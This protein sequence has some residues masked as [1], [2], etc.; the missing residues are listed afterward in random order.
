MHDNAAGFALPAKDLDA[1]HAY[2]NTSLVDL[3]FNS[4][5]FEVDFE[6]HALDKDLPDII[7]D[8]DRYLN[9][10]AQQNPTPL[11]HI[12]D[13]HFRTNEVQIM[14]KNKDTIKV[15]KNGVAYMKFF[16]KEL[17][18]ELQQ[19]GDIRMEIV[20]KP[21]LNYWGSTCTPQ[22]FIESYQIQEDRLIDF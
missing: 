19:Y 14:G 5:Y 18:S 4:D 12:T 15:V 8:L 1:L 22:I 13:L 20:G 16:A 2:A 11:I 3:D 21:N 7:I 9:C 10:W 17:I 6:R